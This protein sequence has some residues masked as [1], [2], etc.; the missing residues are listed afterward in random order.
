[1]VSRENAEDEANMK[2]LVVAIFQFWNADVQAFPCPL[3]HAPEQLV[4]CA[5]SKPVPPH[6][7][8]TAWILLS[9]LLQRRTVMYMTSVCVVKH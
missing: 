7:H 2:L 6:S 3:T 9:R 8:D 4:A 5:I 1:M